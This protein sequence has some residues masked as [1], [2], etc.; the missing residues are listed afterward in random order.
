MKQ[1]GF[2]VTVARPASSREDWFDPKE[3]LYLL[4]YLPA[5]IAN[6]FRH[7]YIKG[8]VTIQ[9]CNFYIGLKH[10]DILIGVLGFLNPDYGFYDIF[11]KADTTISGFKNSVDLLLY[12]L[13]TVE[14]KN[15]L[16]D[17][18]NREINT[19]Y[20][21]VFSQHKQ[22]NRYRKHGKKVQEKVKE[23][24]YDLGYIFELG[25]IPTLKAAKAMFMQKHKL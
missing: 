13:R 9:G 18:F 12:V 25:N 3:P 1:R 2:S 11:L 22:V 23:G 19:A 17:R 24:G 4:P 16:Q 8:F 15:L 7:Q 14:V 5:P 21:M 20:S 6:K 10:K